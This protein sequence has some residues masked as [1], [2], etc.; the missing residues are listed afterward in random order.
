MFAQTQQYDLLLQGGHVIDAKNNVDAVRDV[1][2]R[3]GKIAAV[4]QRI[5]PAQAF[6]VVNVNALYVTHGDARVLTV[7]VSYLHHLLAA[8]LVELRNANA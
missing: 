5:D 4:A 8:L 6:K 2:I 3:D 7:F 1:A